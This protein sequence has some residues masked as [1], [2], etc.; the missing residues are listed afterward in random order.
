MVRPGPALRPE[1]VTAHDLGTDVAGEI[2]REVVVQAPASSGIR[3]IRPARRRARP[4]EQPLGMVTTERSLQTLV[5]T[6]TD[7]VT[8]DIEVHDSQQ[9]IHVFPHQVLSRHRMAK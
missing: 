8:R 4:A 1:L 2:S 5:L 3:T 7:S 6:G 9:L